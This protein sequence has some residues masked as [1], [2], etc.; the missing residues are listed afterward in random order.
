MYRLRNNAWVR[1]ADMATGRRGHSC[2]FYMENIW[3]MDGTDGASVEKYNL[4][5]NTWTSGTS[6]PSSVEYGEAIVF[7]GTIYLAN[8][9]DGKV[10]KLVNQ[11]T[12]E[13]VTNIGQFGFRALFPAPVVAAN[14]LNC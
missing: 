2:I 3:I 1:L 8:P 5:T 9:A 13:Y 14:Y 6:M 7:N 4:M 12:W 10:M 11:T